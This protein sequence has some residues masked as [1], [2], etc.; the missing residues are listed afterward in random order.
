MLKSLAT[1]PWHV[2]CD[3]PRMLQ[4]LLIIYCAI[5]DDLTHF[6]SHFSLWLN[7]GQPDHSKSLIEVYLFLKCEY[8]AEACVLLMA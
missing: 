8:H 1:V 6:N 2:P 4:T 7:N 3:G 5:M